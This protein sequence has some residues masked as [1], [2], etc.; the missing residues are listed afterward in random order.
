MFNSELVKSLQRQIENLEKRIRDI[1]NP[2]KYNVGDKITAIYKPKAGNESLEF[3][4]TGVIV[5]RFYKHEG[6]KWMYGYPEVMKR[7]NYYKVYINSSKQT[8]EIND[9][10]FNI[11][12][13]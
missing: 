4:Y 8:F 9:E 7:V 6:I 10:Y 3:S 2:F 1:E 11:E 5:E 13:K 12:M